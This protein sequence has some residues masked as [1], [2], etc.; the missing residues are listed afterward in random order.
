M[1]VVGRALI[2]ISTSIFPKS[3]LDR[4][5]STGWPYYGSIQ[6]EPLTSNFIFCHFFCHT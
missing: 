5:H 2:N 1:G 3:F 6:F 4:N